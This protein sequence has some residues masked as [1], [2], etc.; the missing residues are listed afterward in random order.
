MVTVFVPSAAEL[1]AD[2]VSRLN[3]VV[4]FGTNDAVTPLGRPDTER[5]TLPV[6][7]YCGFTATLAVPEV[8]WPIFTS[9]ALESVKP[10]G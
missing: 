5:F 10:C 7:P 9:P 1:L 3:P 6:K 4:G 2:K 8:P